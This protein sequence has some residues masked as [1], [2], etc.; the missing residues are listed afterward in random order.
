LDR[1]ETATLIVRRV[2]ALLAVLFVVSLGVFS[3][4]HAAPGDPEQA[5]LG[6]RRLDPE[7]LQAA[8]Q[9]Y[10]LDKPF[11]GQYTTWLGQA[12][13]LD[14]GTS[15][16]TGEEVTDIIGSRLPVTLGLI[17]LAFPAAVL[18]GVGL[19]IYA[20]LRKGTLRDRTV[21]ALSVGG[22][23]TPPFVS[24]IL[25]LFAFS[26]TV[27]IFPAFGAGEGGFDRLSHLVL[28]ALALAATSIGLILKL[29]RV[30]MVEVLDKDFIEFARAR[31]LRRRRI[32]IN[33]ALRNALIPV[34]AASGV[35]LAFMLGG[36]V[37]VEATFELPGLGA[38]LVR[39]VNAQDIPV[40]QGIAIVL[41]VAVAL[42]NL[43]VDLLYLVIDP[44]VRYD[45]PSL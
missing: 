28:P 34:V 41:A 37:L 10:G 2:A 39:A 17:A 1:R 7:A 45:E 36:T 24:G 15:N 26:V 23:S 3:L 11:L 44:R 43:L 25:L 40:I 32:L 22:L 8:R 20:A 4:V 29:T 5:L 18:G 9:R 19:G 31:G 16:R 30:A 21:V 6:P 27:P 38:Q 14:L 35:I 42:V 33:H 13:R 12:V